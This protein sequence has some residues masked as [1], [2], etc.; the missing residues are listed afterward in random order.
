[1][2]APRNLIIL[3]SSIGDLL[4]CNSPPPQ[5]ATGRQTF[6]PQHTATL[7]KSVLPPAQECQIAPLGT[8]ATP[9][10]PKWHQGLP[11]DTRG[12]QRPPKCNPNCCQICHQA[13]TKTSIQASKHP[14]I[15]D[16]RN[17]SFDHLKGEALGPSR[18]PQ[19]ISRRQ[20]PRRPSPPWPSTWCSHP[21]GN[22]K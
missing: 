10:E 1:M 9:V 11:A 12:D 7:P 19:G 16:C 18:G 8:L 15:P 17:P 2:L 22:A 14:S 5:G 13:N 20:S 3:S 4:A 21:P 6:W